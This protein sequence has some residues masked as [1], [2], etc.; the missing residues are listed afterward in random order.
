LC[1]FTN[2]KTVGQYMMPCGISIALMLV[3]LSVCLKF[4]ELLSKKE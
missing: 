4:G 2:F 1:I 3:R